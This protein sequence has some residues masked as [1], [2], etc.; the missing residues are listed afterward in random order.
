MRRHTHKKAMF[1]PDQRSRLIATL[2]QVY[3]E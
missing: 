2:T 3:R 1:S